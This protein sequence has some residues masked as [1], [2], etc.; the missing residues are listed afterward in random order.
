MMD[1]ALPPVHFL[2]FMMLNDS[3]VGYLHMCVRTFC[4]PEYYQEGPELT[5]HLSHHMSSR[6]ASAKKNYVC[7]MCMLLRRDHPID[8]D[9]PPFA[10]ATIRS[11]CIA[12]IELIRTSKR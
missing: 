5:L 12:S 3:S 2:L 10:F 7:P 9:D 6:L 8:S 11:Y 1:R 4:D